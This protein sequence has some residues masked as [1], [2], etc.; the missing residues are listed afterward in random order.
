MR[1]ATARITAAFAALVVVGFSTGCG[2]PPEHHGTGSSAKQRSESADHN[3]D[4]IAFARNM[5]PHHEQAVQMAQMV[6]TNTTNQQVIA[7]A[8]VITTTQIPEVQAFR[9]W[10]MQWQAPE[11]SDSAGQDSHGMP[12]AGMVDQATLDKLPHLNGAEFDRLWLTS[13]IDHHR[14]AIAMAQ[15]EVAHGRNAD[16]LYLARSIIAT[17]QAEIDQMKQML[18]E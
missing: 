9:A 10:L 17:Q 4:D 5:I 12:M 3:A 14:G 15:D 16:A 8:N 13:M 6:P 1:S 2:G 11:G 7:L 18:G